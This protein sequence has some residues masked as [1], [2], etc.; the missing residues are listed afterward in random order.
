MGMTKQAY[1]TKI[2]RYILKREAVRLKGNRC[3]KC[4]WTGNIAGFSF[5][6]PDPTKKE[7]GLSNAITTNWE[8]YW[9]EAEK[10]ELICHNCHMILHSSNADEKFLQDVE[11]YGGRDLISSNVPWKNQNHIPTVYHN[12]C[13]QCNVTYDTNIKTQIFCSVKCKNENNRKCIRPTKDELQ[14]LVLEL[15]FIH[16]A[17]RYGV[18]D[19]AIRKWCKSYNIN[20]K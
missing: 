12:T 4:G 14:K 16:I 20:Y 8:K 1:L 6:H 13:K 10:C 17:K 3:I 2:R 11:N 15:P 18:S 19:N 9:K 5:H 7:F